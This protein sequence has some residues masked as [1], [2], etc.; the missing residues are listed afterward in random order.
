MSKKKRLP[1][2][3]L[4]TKSELQS[5]ISE[6]IAWNPVIGN[7]CHEYSLKLYRRILKILDL[8][9]VIPVMDVP[10]RTLLEKDVF[11]RVEMTKEAIKNEELL[12]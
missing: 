7:D 9:R 1:Q 11:V 4:M 10:V 2:V 8:H 6:A 12:K 5:A 3:I